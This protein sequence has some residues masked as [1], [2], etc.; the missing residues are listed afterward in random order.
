MNSVR[1]LATGVSLLTAPL[2]AALACGSSGESGSNSGSGGGGGAGPD[3]GPDST[4][5]SDRDGIP[6]DDFVDRL[7][8]YVSTQEDGPGL[9]A[10]RPAQ[11]DEP[12]QLIDPNVTMTS[13]FSTTFPIAE[14]EGGSS[15]HLRPQGV[16]YNAGDSFPPVAGEL[17]SIKTYLVTTDVDQLDS[18]PTQISDLD[19]GTSFNGSSAY[20]AHGDSLTTSSIWLSVGNRRLNL[21][22]SADDA[23]LDLPEG[24]KMLGSTLGE[25]SRTHDHWLYID[26]DGTLQ[27]Y[28]EDFRDS[29][30]VIDEA[31]GD[32]LEDL[33]VA[34]GFVAHLGVEHLLVLLADADHEGTGTLYRVTRPSGDG[35][36]TARQLLNDSDE[37]IELALPGSILGRTIPGEDRRWQDTEAFYFAEGASVI[38]SAT[39]AR[40]TRVT[41]DGWTAVEIEGDLTAAFTPNI[42]VR[43]SGAFFWAPSFEPELIA[44][45]AGDPSSWQRTPLPDAPGPSETSIYS[46]AGDWVYYQSN[47]DEAVAFNVQTGDVV[48]FAESTWMGASFVSEIGEEIRTDLIARQQLSTVLVHLGDNRLGAVE[49]GD[50]QAGVVIL[51][52]LP[53]T[54]ESVQ[55]NGPGIGPARLVRVE[56]ED[57]SVEIVAV[58]TRQSGSLRHLMDSPAVEWSYDTA[59]GSTT[60]ELDVSPAATAPLKMF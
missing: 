8:Y 24:G 40:V 1:R 16:L 17:P 19:S 46:S 23:P 35:E 59:L 31:S 44:P 3:P 21:D 56:H 26:A 42:F 53:E 14:T 7:H 38:N 11:P 52:E 20:M 6:S 18:E 49:A 12:P 41:A 15:L 34:G 13:V 22:M 54:T 48:S 47:D 10:Y 25:D 2:M 30:A 57:G 29:A 55:V 28:D 32:P 43:T 9:Y 39:P 58:D 45:D 33:A 60:I 36:S 5:V 27:F 51:G 37:P 50:P 4:E